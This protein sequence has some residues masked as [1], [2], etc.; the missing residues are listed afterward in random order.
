MCR[1]R[2]E[3]KESAM[4]RIGAVL[5]LAILIALFI[6][7]VI[8]GCGGNGVPAGRKTIRL[9]LATTTSTENSGLL[10]FLLPH[11]EAAYGIAVDVLAVGTGQALRLGERG[12]VDVVLVHAPQ[13]EKDFMKAGYG[14]NRRRIMHNDFVLLG[15]KEDPAGIAGLGDGALALKGIAEKGAPF[16]SRGDES[17]TH[18]REKSLWK[19]AGGAPPAGTYM[20]TGQG[21]GATLLIAHEKRAYV[22]A[23]RGTFLA[24]QG[25]I[26]LPVLVEGDP[27]LLNPYSVIAVNP[28]RHGHVRYV[29]AMTFIGWLT[30]PKAQKRIGEFR[31]GGEILFHPDAVQGK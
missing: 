26:E 29:E 13:A 30:S 5:G 23:D 19:K 25:K 7:S 16:A 28:A 3:R 4:R 1:E 14:V 17:G 21:M 2:G 12:D 10:D 31:K 22:L 24:F 15:P 11:F 18:K 8:G 27:A 6:T 9:K 20:E